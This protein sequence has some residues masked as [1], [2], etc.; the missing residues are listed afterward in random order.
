MSVEDI[1]SQV[2]LFQVPQLHENI[3][4]SILGC[5][6]LNMEKI[7]SD[8]K[9]AGHRLAHLIADGWS[10]GSHKPKMTL[11]D[12]PTGTLLLCYKDIK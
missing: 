5:D 6:Q 10:I 1:L 11:F 12:A 9:W 2:G 3:P 8:F 7:L 4:V